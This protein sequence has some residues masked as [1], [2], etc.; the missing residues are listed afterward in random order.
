MVEHTAYMC[1][2]E[3]TVEAQRG[4]GLTR[5]SDYPDRLPVRSLLG[6]A[7][8]R[9]NQTCRANEQRATLWND[10][11]S[12]EEKNMTVF[13]DASRNESCKLRVSSL[14]AADRGPCTAKLR[15]HVVQRAATL[16]NGR[17]PCGNNGMS[18]WGLL[19]NLFCTESMC[20]GF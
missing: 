16:G 2:R 11:E 17:S 6:A 13:R 10:P 19:Q 20:G 12:D 14:L 8:L 7:G 1:D 3:Y 5:R 4:W 18:D 15:T 9:L